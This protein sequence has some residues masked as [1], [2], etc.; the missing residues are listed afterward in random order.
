[1]GRGENY[2]HNMKGVCKGVDGHSLNRFNRFR[3]L[4]QAGN[5]DGDGR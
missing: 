2:E 1:M 5:K 4:G 3:F